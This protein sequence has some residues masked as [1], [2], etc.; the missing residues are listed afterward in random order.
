MK[1]AVKRL[2][3]KEMRI[4]LICRKKY[5]GLLVKFDGGNVD[6]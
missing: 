2:E 6:I 3:L 1:E 4:A 5:I